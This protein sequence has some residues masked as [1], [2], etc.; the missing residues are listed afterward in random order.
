M[1]YV[2][3]AAPYTHGD[4]EENTKNAIIAGDKIAE[5]GYIPFIPHLN[6]Y[7]D[8]LKPHEYRFWMDQDKAWLLKCD[9]L[10]RLPGE[11]K[12]ADE[13]VVI[14]LDNNI[15][16]YFGIDEFLDFMGLEIC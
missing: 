16:V 11:S 14:A 8:Q 6:H 1:K 12:G 15:P 4:K 5:A 13:E 10:V 7:W 3:I 9:A 2:Y